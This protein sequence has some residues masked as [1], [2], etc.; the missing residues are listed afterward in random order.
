MPKDYMKDHQKA[1]KELINREDEVI[2]PADKGNATV[3]RG[4][5]TIRR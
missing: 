2:P 4:A 1:L 5:T 3:V